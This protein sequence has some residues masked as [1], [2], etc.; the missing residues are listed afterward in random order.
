MAFP[1]AA[2]AGLAIGGLQ[3]GMGAKASQAAYQQ[4]VQNYKDQLKYQRVSDKYARWTAKINTRVANTSAKYKYFADT[5]QHNQN[6]SY[7]NQLRNFELVK[8]YNQ[9]KVVKD[10]RTSAMSDY[11]QQAQALSE[12]IREQASADAVSYYQYVQ[13]GIRA[14]S[15]VMANEQEGASA[16]RIYRDYARQIG[17]METLQTINQK[18]RDRQYSREQAGQV[19]QYLSRYNSQQFYQQQIYQDPIKPFAP[20]PTLV[21]PQAP[22]MTGAGP[23]AAAAG[24]NTMSA[25]LGGINAG[26]STWQ[27]LQQFTNSGK[28]NG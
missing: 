4:Q 22:S 11:A 5:V 12:G 21:M 7:V 9:A 18:F 3:A 17:D 2:L 13:Q 16:D 27:S 26:V 15:A 14:R 28:P 6:L 10:T 20:L 1:F 25:V 23:S 24:L 8:A 19:A